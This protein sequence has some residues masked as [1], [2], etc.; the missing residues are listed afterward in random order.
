M[1]AEAASGSGRQLFVGGDAGG[2]L[3]GEA[4][5][6]R[7]W[8]RWQQGQVDVDELMDIMDGCG[9][10]PVVAVNGADGFSE[11]RRP[12]GLRKKNAHGHCCDDRRSDQGQ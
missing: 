5:G 3:I 2:E 7:R 6:E 10:Q 1:A 9:R 11:N 8:D 12:D 4:A